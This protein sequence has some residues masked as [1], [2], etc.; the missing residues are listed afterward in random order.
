MYVLCVA[1]LAAVLSISSVSAQNI[2]RSPMGE[3]SPGVAAFLF[4]PGFFS[5]VPGHGPRIG[6]FPGIEIRRP[7]RGLLPFDRFLFHHG[8]GFFMRNR[9][10]DYPYAVPY[11]GPSSIWSSRRFVDRWVAE[12][13]I[14]VVPS[15]NFSESI[16]L[17]E[18]LT[19]EE[20]MRRLGSPLQ[21]IQMG[22]REVWR[23]S[24]YSLIFESGKLKEIR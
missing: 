3:K 7:F 4:G 24:G 13:P 2:H 21:R 23:Y 11:A 6:V 9:P 19:E 20:V 8:S 15:H 1:L 12:E 10:F 22:V 14:Q 17:E 5:F 18:G 16:L